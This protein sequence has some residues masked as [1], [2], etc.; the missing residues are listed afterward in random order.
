VNF[1][2]AM[3]DANYAVACCAT[4]EGGN[5]GIARLPFQQLPQ[6]GSVALYVST[7]S[8]GQ[9]SRFVSVAVFR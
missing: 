7:P 9:D 3:P 8:T 4:D 2:T 5:G 1:T 6:T